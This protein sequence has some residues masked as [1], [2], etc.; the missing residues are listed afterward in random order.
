V[1][2]AEWLEL[3]LGNGCKLDTGECHGPQTGEPGDIGTFDELLDA[4]HAQMADG[5]RRSVIR[6]NRGE[7][8]KWQQMPRPMM[9]ALTQGCIEKA[10]D[11]TEGGALY[12]MSGFQAFGLGT[13]VDSLAAIRALVYGDHELTL[14]E[15]V[16]ILRND[17]EGHDELRV[18]TKTAMPH[19]G[20]DDDTVDA[21]A[22]DAVKALETEIARHTNIRGGPFILGLWSF[23]QHVNYGKTMAASADGRKHGEI[24]SH[25]M[26]PSVGTAMEGPTAAIR[27]ASKIDTSGL[28]NGGSLLLDFDSK[29]LQSEAGMHAVIN[30]IRTYFGLG[31]IQLQL[32]TVA[33]EV[34][35]DA[36]EHPERH[37]HLVVRMAGY[38]DYFTGQSPERQAF[39]I[40]REKHGGT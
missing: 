27:S 17:W 38:C 16:E 12:N 26:G 3:A 21:L 28:A 23:W 36:V 40:A 15:L 24:L 7:P 14:S 13:L 25:S 22:V 30:L 33:P 37:R 29:L 35:E 31:G 2:F 6:A 1:C 32:S 20:N 8:V 39:I 11:F 19:W 34:L 10:L 5:V 4:W 18:R 9:S